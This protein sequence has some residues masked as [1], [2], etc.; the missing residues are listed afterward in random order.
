[1]V[2][3]KH[4]GIKGMHWG[5]RKSKE[6]IARS[7]AIKKANSDFQANL[8][9]LKAS[10]QENDTEAVTRIA[11]KHDAQLAKAKSM[12]KRPSPSEDSNVAS[13]LK[14]KRLN[15]LSNAELTTLTKRLQLERQY[16]DL[17][18]KRPSGVV[19]WLADVANNA[20]KQL[21]TDFTKDVM[22]GT[23]NELAKQTNVVQSLKDL[24]ETL[25][26]RD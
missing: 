1:M 24:K 4:W 21:A 2:Y 15:E 7:N 11:K 6:S 12:P 8:K 13:I 5:I 17:S 25:N 20:G 18:T 10:G 19:K 16:K 14:K 9:K 3:L 22:K 23:L 26:N